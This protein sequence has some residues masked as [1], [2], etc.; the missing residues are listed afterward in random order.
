MKTFLKLTGI[1]AIVVFLFTACDVFVLLPA[2][3]HNPDDPNQAFGPLKAGIIDDGTVRV[4][5]DWYDLERKVRGLEPVYDEIVIKHN[6]GN[7]PDSRLGGKV[8]EIKNWDPAT[9]PLWATTFSDLKSD[10]EHYFAL[11]AHEKDGRWVGPIY[12]SIYMEG[13]EFS[14]R[15]GLTPITSI[16]VDATPPPP[17]PPPPPFPAATTITTAAYPLI[18][19]DTQTMI[20]YFDD[21]WDDEKIISAKLFIEVNTGP[22]NPDSLII[23]PMRSYVEE[24]SGTLSDY[25]GLYGFTVDRTVFSEYPLSATDTGPKEIDITDVFVKAHYHRHDGIYLKM[26]GLESLELGIPEPYIEI[27]IAR[28]W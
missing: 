18:I 28:N 23:Y 26:A 15:P 3:N 14:T 6:R 13:F 2:F 11:Y 20:Y 9:N 8:F 17:P 21:I 24:T 27:E 19:S 10:R 16:S 25:I 1:F 4:V 7:Y 22:A 12:T 5:W